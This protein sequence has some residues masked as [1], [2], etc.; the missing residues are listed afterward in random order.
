[1]RV[2]R[3][4]RISLASIHAVKRLVEY[5]PE[6]KNVLFRTESKETLLP[7]LE[8]TYQELHAQIEP[9]AKARAERE[10]EDAMLSFE[11]RDSDIRKR[12]LEEH[13]ISP[14]Q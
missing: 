1:M 14:P 9:G 4:W 11:K 12:L 6:R 13:G 10:I 5:E 3:Y 7:I 2:F 8:D